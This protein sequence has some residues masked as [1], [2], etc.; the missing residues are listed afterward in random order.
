MP[1]YALFLY[2]LQGFGVDVSICY[3][4]DTDSEY[5][6]GLL[7]LPKFATKGFENDEPY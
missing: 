1:Y 5:Y 7:R 6:L 2:N 4:S 3:T